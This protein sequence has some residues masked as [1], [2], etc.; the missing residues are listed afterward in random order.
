MI[1]NG[2]VYD[3]GSIN[4][5]I[6]GLSIEAQSIDYDDELES[7][8]VYGRGM[9]PRGYGNGNYKAS[10]KISLLR[11]DYNDILDYC[12]QKGIPFYKLVIEKIIV[13]YA[14]EGQATRSDVINK[15]KFSKRTNKA[16]NGD[17]SFKVDL[18]LL[19]MG[20]IVQD[21]VEPI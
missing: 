10:G 17:K 15:V 5:E 21:G 20:K 9:L 19:V 8:L 6:P 18:D 13:S 11:D 14:N 1:I 3:W 16:A 7:E 4:I 2:K 12:K